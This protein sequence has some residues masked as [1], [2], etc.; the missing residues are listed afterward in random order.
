MPL[1]EIKSS[2][3]GA[4]EYNPSTQTLTITFARR[5]GQAPSPRYH[6]KPVPQD[7]VDQFLAAESKGTFFLK[8]IKPKFACVKEEKL[9]TENNRE[10]VGRVQQ[11]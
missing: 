4:Y 11:E 3:L 10:D 1:T 9:G 7:V 8:E 5:E 2:L 6:Y